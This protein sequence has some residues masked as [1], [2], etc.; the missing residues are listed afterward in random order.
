M[1][2]RTSYFSTSLYINSHSSTFPHS[3][4]LVYCPQPLDMTSLLSPSMRSI[5]LDSTCEWVPV[6][7]C[8]AY[9]TYR[10]GLQFCLCY[11][12]WQN[13]ILLWP[14]TIPQCVCTTFSLFIIDGHR[15]WLHFLALVNSASGSTECRC[16]FGTPVLF[17]L[18]THP[19]PGC[20]HDEVVLF[21]TFWGPPYCLSSILA[22]STQPVCTRVC[23]CAV[24]PFSPFFHIRQHLSSVV[25]LTMVISWGW[26]GRS[27]CF[28]LHFLDD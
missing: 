20:L 6:F 3:P 12:R 22:V 1:H 23:Q 11:C 13:F 7:L 24:V 15:G 26:D 14:S 27:L 2:K 9:F 19:V 10:N 17:P 8:L 5:F 16:V 25:F 28:D 4:P 21:L 18:D